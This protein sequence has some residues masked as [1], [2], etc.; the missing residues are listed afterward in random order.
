[1]RKAR[2]ARDKSEAETA[3]RAMDWAEAKDKDNVDIDRLDE[4][5]R[6]KTKF[7]AMATK[8]TNAVNRADVEAIV[9]IRF[10]SDIQGVKRNRGED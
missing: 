4:K 1:M 2:E 7:M 6:E 10:S 5:A 8:N 3:E 9:K